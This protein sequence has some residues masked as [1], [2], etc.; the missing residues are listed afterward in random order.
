MRRWLDRN[1][2]ELMTVLALI[3]AALLIFYAYI[4]KGL[5]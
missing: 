5:K 3:I 2:N 4:Y 1:I